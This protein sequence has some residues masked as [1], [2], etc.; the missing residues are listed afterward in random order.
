[1]RN[2]TD[3]DAETFFT[4]TIY[5]ASRGHEFKMNKPRAI[6]NLRAHFFSHRV[7]NSW[8]K[9]PGVVLNASSVVAFKRL[10]DACWVSVFEDL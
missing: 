1:M 6:T 2:Y 4:K 9:L 3:I 5:P 8:N 7:V 10:L